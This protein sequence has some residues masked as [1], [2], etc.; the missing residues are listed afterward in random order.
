MLQMRRQNYLNNLSQYKGL[1]LRAIA[2]KT[3]HHFNTVKKY[4]DK[5][6]WNSGVMPQEERKTKLEPL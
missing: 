3:D 1:S 6:N 2:E 5:A 4:V